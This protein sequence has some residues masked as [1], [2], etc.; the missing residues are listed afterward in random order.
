M[1]D[2]RL[3]S[4]GVCLS[5]CHFKV[6]LPGPTTQ[7]LRTARMAVQTLAVQADDA[8]SPTQRVQQCPVVVCL[9]RVVGTVERPH[10]GVWTR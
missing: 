5:V 3:P 8:V 10:L 1:N 6:W 7:L 9:G 2:E 4:N